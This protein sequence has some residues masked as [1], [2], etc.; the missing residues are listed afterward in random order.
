MTIEQDLAG[1][2]LIINTQQAPIAAGAC[3]LINHVLQG[4]A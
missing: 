4:R 1:H 2:A 3:Q